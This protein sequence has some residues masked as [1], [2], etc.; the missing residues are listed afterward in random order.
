MTLRNQVGLLLLQPPYVEPIL[1]VHMRKGSRYTGPNLSSEIRNRQTRNVVDEV[2]LSQEQPLEETTPRP[3]PL[4]HSCKETWFGQCTQK[5]SVS[6]QRAPIKKPHAQPQMLARMW[7]NRDSRLW[8]MGTQ[9]GIATL[10]DS[11]A[12]CRKLNILLHCDPGLMLLKAWKTY[13]S[14]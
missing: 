9:S 8:L 3:G 10:E 1:L 2:P 7:S 5:R 14:T 6:K 13:I 4:L 11:L 12:V